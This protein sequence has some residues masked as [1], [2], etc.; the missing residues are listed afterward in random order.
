VYAGGTYPTFH[1]RGGGKKRKKRYTPFFN[2]GRVQ[3]GITKREESEILTTYNV[4]CITWSKRKK[5]RGGG[6]SDEALDLSA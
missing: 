4:S 3:P 1:D 5:E 2:F 6:G